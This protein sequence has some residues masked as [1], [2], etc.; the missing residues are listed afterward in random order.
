MDG[1]S[2]ALL[3]I[4]TLR[5]T[6]DAETRRLATS[7][8]SYDGHQTCEYESETPRSF[9]LV[10]PRSWDPPPPLVYDVSSYT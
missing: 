1:N 4:K 2:T 7:H 6:A 3:R 9:P 8:R 10:F 5:V